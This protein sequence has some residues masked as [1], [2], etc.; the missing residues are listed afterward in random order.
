M[1]DDQAGVQGQ[2]R[3]GRPRIKRN[4][5]FSGPVRCYVP[6]CN[7]PG[8][9]ENVILMPEEL[10]LLRLVDFE[11][12]EQE[13][14]AS[15]MGISRRTAWRD[16]HNARRKVVDALLHGKQIEMESCILKAQNLCP[17]MRGEICPKEDGETCPRRWTQKFPPTPASPDN[18]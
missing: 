8:T 2:A 7:I 3:R 15:V 9:T 1:N 17:R 14:A 5:E 11:G 16:L 10:E 13:E 4:I 18:R 6:Q 12:L